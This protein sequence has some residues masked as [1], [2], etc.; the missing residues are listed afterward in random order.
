MKYL[1][2]PS[3]GVNPALMIRCMLSH[4]QTDTDRSEKQWVKHSIDKNGLKISVFE[5]QSK[6]A[7]NT[8]KAKKTGTKNME[9]DKNNHIIRAQ[10]NK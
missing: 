7:F 2:D 6:Q 4:I 3:P 5:D 9:G 8:K 10:I 1:M